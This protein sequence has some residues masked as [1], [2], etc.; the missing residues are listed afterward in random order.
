MEEEFANYESSYFIMNVPTDA[1]LEIN[2][3][4]EKDFA[5]FFHEYIH[6][7]QDITSFF[8]YF[9]I[10]SHG[11][12]IRRV[13]NDIY[14]TDNPILLP[15]ELEDKGDFVLLNKK[16][17]E[18]SLGDKGNRNHVYI[19]DTFIESFSLSDTFELPELHVKAIVDREEEEIIVGAYA[20]REN[21][22][23]LLEKKCTTKYMR[24]AEFPYQIV[25]L[26]ADKICPNMLSDLDLIALCDIS[27]QNSTPGLYLYSMLDDISKGKV[28][29]NKPEDIYDSFFSKKVNFLNQTMMTSEAIL[30]AAKQAVNHLLSYVRIDLLSKE[31]QEWVVF[32]IMSGVALRLYWPYF[33]L[34][35]AKGKRNKGNE[36][37]MFLA[38]TIGSPQ[39][40][41]KNGMRFQ[42]TTNRP[43]CRFEYLEVVREIENL[44][45]YGT[46]RC[47]L[48]QWCRMSPN[49]A[50]VDERCD[51]NPWERCHD[52]QLCPYGL[53]W[54]H[55]KLG[56][57]EIVC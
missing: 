10:Y 19:K 14:I 34:E 28:I 7:I 35:M 53:L 2:S 9:G 39:M 5:I 54:K 11:E 22:A 48:K 30:L 51:N 4:N 42:L 40:V 18:L 31:Y 32:T 27:L 47:G 44:F 49:G 13:V 20:I 45:E 56:D 50:P 15:I 16:L 52:N 8:G 24:S 46:K 41:N 26:L 43:I 55:W 23:Y 37:L 1:D 3:M 17:A 33:F 25:E 21:M 57:K 12:Y 38:K 36:M 6:F 29:I